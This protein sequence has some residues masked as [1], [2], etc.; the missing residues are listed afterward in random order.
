MKTQET[1]G[2]A[3]VRVRPRSS[4]QE[5]DNVHRHIDATSLCEVTLNA[6]SAAARHGKNK[7]PNFGPRRV[8]QGQTQFAGLVPPSQHYLV[9]TS[10]CNTSSF[11]LGLIKEFSA[12]LAPKPSWLSG[13]ASHLYAGTSAVSRSLQTILHAKITRSIRVVGIFWPFF[14]HNTT[15]MDWKMPWRVSE[16]HQMKGKKGNHV[17]RDCATSHKPCLLP[18]GKSGVK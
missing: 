2:N 18:R 14:W 6:G 7:C 8:G 12:V 1:L 13:K 15:S 3:Y 9:S 10:S 11:Q 4:R 16:M 17:F 5:I